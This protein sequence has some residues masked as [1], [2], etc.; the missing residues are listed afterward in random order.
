MTDGS[1]TWIG[2][3]PGGRGC[4]GVAIWEEDAAPETCCVDCAEEA[5]Q[6]V[7]SRMKG[8]RPAGV[9]VDAPLW[10]SA[11]ASS[12]RQADRWLRRTY[13]LSGGAVQTAN[14]LKGSCLVQ[15]AMFIERLAEAQRK[16]LWSIFERVRSALAE[17]QQITH[18]QM[19]T[20]LAAVLTKAR[21]PAFD[22]A[23]VDEAQDLTVAQ[24]R[25]LATLGAG[26]PNALFF[27]GDLG[28]RIFQQPYS[29]KALGV[30][31]R[32]RSRTLRVNYR[33]SHQIRSQADRLL[34]PVVM[35]VDG[36][37]EDRSHT[38]SVFNGPSPT[39]QALKDEKQE[40][41]AVADWIAN[42][43]MCSE[44]RFGACFQD[45]RK[46]VLWLLGCRASNL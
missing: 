17:R 37:A 13:K 16:V 44:T 4:F 15:A 5:V 21:Y 6:V 25:F 1:P 33:T 26:R 8:R 30:G 20:A 29:W 43:W 3:D 38:V 28:Q 23:V 19:F 40:A 32:G 45:A 14:S 27:A 24:L 12:D 36:N 11:G 18:A 35:D 22:F 10:W 41:K 34:G 46:E 31:I 42:H 7:T 2:A 39:I 9:G